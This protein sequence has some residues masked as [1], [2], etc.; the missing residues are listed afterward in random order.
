[1]KSTFLSLNVKDI[2]RGFFLAV[3]GAIFMAIVKFFEQGTVEWTWAFWQP[4]VYTGLAAGI[5]YLLKNV[6][7]NSEDE[8]GKGEKPK[9][10]TTDRQTRMKL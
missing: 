8:F 2:V 4:I 1:M 10:P 5:T 7:T 6:F 3:F 9:L